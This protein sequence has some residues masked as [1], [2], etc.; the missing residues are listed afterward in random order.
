[1][2]TPVLPAP[3]A[4]AAL[5]PAFAPPTPPAFGSTYTSYGPVAAPKTRGAR[6]R[7]RRRLAWLTVAFL[8]CSL[9]V[10][11]GFLLARAAFPTTL[12]APD[13]Q[14]LSL[15]DARRMAEQAGL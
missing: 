12:S 6:R 4:T 7:W 11:V 8:I 15:I 9:F 10:A 2:S 14:R 3:P 5:A 13:L 1:L